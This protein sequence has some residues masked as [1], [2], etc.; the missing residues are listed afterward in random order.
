MSTNGID[1][2]LIANPMAR[3]YESA[4]TFV[5]ALENTSWGLACMSNSVSSTI[6]HVPPWD[7]YIAN[8]SE[9]RLK[10]G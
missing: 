7:R 5:C 3:K 8:S 10:V 2:S 4:T 9:I 1:A 6:G